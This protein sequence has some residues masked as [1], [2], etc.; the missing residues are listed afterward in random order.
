MLFLADPRPTRLSQDKYNTR[1]MAASSPSASSSG[2]QGPPT[3]PPVERPP[4]SALVESLSAF[5]QHL[6]TNEHVLATE[7]GDEALAGEALGATK[8]IFDIGEC[9]TSN[10]LPMNMQL[11]YLQNPLSQPSPSNHLP[12]LTST[13]SSPNSPTLLLSLQQ[14][15]PPVQLH[16]NPVKSP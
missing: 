13:A 10:H 9:D 16:A 1:T 15:R 5:A 14:P 2:S 6:R 7:D 3:P 8:R 4:P 12:T 11:T